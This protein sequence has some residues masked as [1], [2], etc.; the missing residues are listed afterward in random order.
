[1]GADCHT[2]QPAT[3]GG[4]D[5]DL[6]GTP[7]QFPAGMTF[8]VNPYPAIPGAVSQV[9]KVFTARTSS[10]YGYGYCVQIQALTAE[11]DLEDNSYY[12]YIPLSLYVA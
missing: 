11:T 5:I 10:I 8:V 12:D 4:H 9:S 2:S 6:T 7:F 1:M 3:P